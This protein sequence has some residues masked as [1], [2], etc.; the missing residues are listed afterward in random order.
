MQNAVARDSWGILLLAQDPARNS[1]RV[2]FL[3]LKGLAGASG[4]G[5]VLKAGGYE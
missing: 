1:T 3:R 4:W 5:K 2:A